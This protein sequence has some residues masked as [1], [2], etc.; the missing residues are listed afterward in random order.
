MN[1]VA[2]TLVLAWGNRARG[3]DALGPLLADRLR[4]LELPGVEVLEEHQ[5]A[6]EHALDLVGRE[7]VLFVDAAAGMAEPFTV[8]LLEPA[9]DRSLASHALSPAALLQVHAQVQGTAP[10]PAW[11]L[12]LRADSFELGAPPRPAALAALDAGVD[13]ARRWTQLAFG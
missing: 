9:A 13:W 5:L 7:R 10:P 3:D 6:P 11:L 4:E 8:T 1:G 12:A 2:P